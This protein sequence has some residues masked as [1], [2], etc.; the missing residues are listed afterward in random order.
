MAF[1]VYCGSHNDGQFCGNCGQPQ[2]LEK[3]KSKKSK[4][5]PRVA[6]IVSS[7][8]TV[9]LVL[10]TTF[11][12]RQYISPFE[13]PLQVQISNQMERNF[14][15]SNFYSL[16]IN[17]VGTQ[18]PSFNKSTESAQFWESDSA[19]TLELSS[20]I[21]GEQDLAFSAVPRELGLLGSNS[22]KALGLFFT[23]EQDHFSVE[24]VLDPSGK[25]E[26][27]YSKKSKRVNYERL[28]EKCNE[29]NGQEVNF[30]LA[31]ARGV[32]TK[33]YNAVSDAQLNGTRTLLYTVWASRSDKLQGLIRD[34]RNSAPTYTSDI[35]LDRWRDMLR[36][37][38][39]LEDAWQNLESVARAEQDSRWDAAWERIF[40][41]ERSISSLV[42][43]VGRVENLIN[44]Y[45]I[46]KLTN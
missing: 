13:G 37:L 20:Q 42:A 34:I 2:T 12:V 32:E 44:E 3:A 43:N 18:I 26:L 4:Q 40:D 33:Y 9:L 25:P 5:L 39:A 6:I 21:V 29:E 8:F 14:L 41:E 17:G 35:G 23:V 31:F 36:G 28:L 30:E 38:E 24:L 27:L 16:S 45:C 22:G 19:I 46:D 10:G 1:C 11:I 15:R 7:V